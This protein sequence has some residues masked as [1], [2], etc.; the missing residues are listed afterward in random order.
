MSLKE[1]VDIIH[2]GELGNWKKR[3]QDALDSIFGGGGG[4]YPDRA[5][6]SVKL[7]AP[8]REIPFAAYIHANTTNEGA[9]GGLSFVVFPVNGQ[10]A[11]FGLVV[12]TQGLDPDENVLGRPGHARKVQAICAWLNAGFGNKHQVAW[13][14]YDPTRIDI[15]VPEKLQR[16]WSEFEGAFSKYSGVMYGLYRPTKKRDQTL[17]AVTAFLDLMFEERGFEPLGHAQ[18]DKKRIESEWFSHLMPN[19]DRGG[20]KQLLDENRFV[21]IQGPPGTGKTRMALEIIENEYTGNGRTIQLHPNATYENFVGGLAPEQSRDALGLRFR[22]MPGF[23]MQAADAARRVQPKPYLLHIDE[24]NRADLSK[25]LGEAIYL[26][27]PKADKTRKVALAYDFGDPFYASLSLPSNLHLLGTMNTADRSI[28]I[29]DVA[30][31]RRFAFIALWPR[32]EVVERLGCELMQDAFREIL[33]LFVE[34]AQE[35]AFNLVPGHSYFL[36]KD[37]DKAVRSLKTGVAPLLEEYLAQGYVAAFAE[38]V[39]SYLQWVRSL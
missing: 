15:N 12:G 20:V 36:E 27:E 16:D 18:A 25:V 3:N 28:A 23:L 32:M 19:V 1:I 22:P 5:K 26:L 37:K 39:R 6:N 24:V 30:V 10:P 31:R 9:Y 35:D 34:Y 7:R 8:D 33:R 13:A 17:E 2:S 14:K 38:Q 21:V 11:L 4:R 29:V